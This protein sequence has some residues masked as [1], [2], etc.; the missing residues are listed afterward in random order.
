[1]P[2]LVAST[3]LCTRSVCPSS[4]GNSIERAERKELLVKLHLGAHC[5][6]RILPPSATGP[7]RRRIQFGVVPEDSHLV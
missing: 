6:R 2:A 4:L 3:G 7:R 5:L 1:M